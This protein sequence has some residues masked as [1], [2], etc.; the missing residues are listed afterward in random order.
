MDTQAFSAALERDGF[1]EISTRTQDALR[2]NTAHSHPFEVRAL[3]LEGE[4]SLTFEGRTQLCRP[5]DVF[6]MKAGCEHAEK[7]GPQGATYLV[8]RK[9]P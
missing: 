2:E 1:S 7:F 3:M 4:L 5:G 6:T 8:G 9:Q